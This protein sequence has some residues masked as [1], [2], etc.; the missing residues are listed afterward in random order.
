MLLVEPEIHKILSRTLGPWP[1]RLCSL[2]NG[3]SPCSLVLFS[4]PRSL[5]NG[6]FEVCM[7]FYIA[8]NRKNLLISMAE[9]MVQWLGKPAAVPEVPGSNPG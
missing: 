5:V 4:S 3:S 2:V 7:F 1:R 9:Q 8:Q 6:M